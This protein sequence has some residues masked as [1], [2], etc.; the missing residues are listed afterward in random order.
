M[1]L[2]KRA[3]VAKSDQDKYYKQ[4]IEKFSN[5]GFDPFNSN[6]SS[7]IYFLKFID[8]KKTTTDFIRRQQ[9]LLKEV[10]DKP[11]EEQDDLFGNS[12][13][14]KYP[15]PSTEHLSVSNVLFN[16]NLSFRS[17]Y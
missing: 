5:S 16:H 10:L 15:F 6:K 2:R 11:K 8:F 12:I 4:E 14:R 9:N 3:K 1:M 13:M 17:K 7:I